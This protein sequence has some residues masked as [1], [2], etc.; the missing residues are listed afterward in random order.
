[1]LDISGEGMLDMLGKTQV[2]QLLMM[3]ASLK[4][5]Y[6]N[7]GKGGHQFLSGREVCRCFRQRMVDLAS[8][9]SAQNL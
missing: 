5:L 2:S 4:Y 9:W 8:I 7:T 1:M 3:S 6:S